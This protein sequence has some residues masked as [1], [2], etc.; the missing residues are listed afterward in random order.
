MD[1]RTIVDRRRDRRL[2]WVCGAMLARRR[3]AG[4][5]S[6][7]P[8]T[9]S[10]AINLGLP[11]R[12]IPRPGSLEEGRPGR[13]PRRR[14]SAP[15]LVMLIGGGIALPIGVATAIF[16][17]EYRRPAWLAQPRRERDRGASS[18]IPAIV[19]ALF[20][21]RCSRTRSSGPSRTRSESRAA[22]TASR[23][24]WPGSMLSLIALPP[25][26]RS[27]QEAIQAVP[28]E[29]REASFALGKGRLAT[30]GAS[31]CRAPGRESRPGSSS[32]RPDR[33]RHGDHLAPAGR[34]DHAVRRPAGWAA[35]DRDAARDRRDAHVLHLLRVAGGRGQQRLEGLRRRVRAHRSSC[36]S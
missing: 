24:S 21:L 35:L 12:W 32:A 2:A 9:A 5:S 23:S 29:L 11:R 15:S 30:C 14:S 6:G 8:S 22:P 10:R 36:S 7:S 27:T 16:L 34:G 26:I 31:S 17:T 13:H 25:I 4:S 19:F 28:P 1:S 3:S 33:R 18:A 20:G